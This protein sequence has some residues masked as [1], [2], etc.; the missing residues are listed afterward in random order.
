VIPQV[1][2]VERLR[3]RHRD[4]SEALATLSRAASSPRVA[5]ALQRASERRAR[6]AR[7]LRAHVSRREH[8]GESSR[9]NWI[10]A[11]PP[12]L[13][14]TATHR[15]LA[16]VADREVAAAEEC[17]RLLERA[18]STAPSPMLA[19]HARLLRRGRGSLLAS[20]PV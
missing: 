18:R 5:C 17:E 10:R 7:E 14:G 8:T 19:R 13:S 11:I 1:D 15:A 16:I 9:W 20:V 6:L 3:R 2:P 12:S 4:A